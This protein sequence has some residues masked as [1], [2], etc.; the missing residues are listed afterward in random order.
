MNIFNTKIL[1]NRQ[2]WQR[3]LLFSALGTVLCILL[4][5]FLQRMFR[6][7]SS[8]FYL[9]S[10]LFMG[11]LIQESGHGV[12]KKFSILAVVCMILIIFFSD[13]FYFFGTNAL[14]NL[15]TAMFY[16]VQSYLH[17]DFSSLLSLLIKAAF[18]GIAY[19]RARVL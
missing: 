19:E 1:N 12:Q 6:I 16:T 14:Y 10:S 11:W 13:M 3:A 4:C 7:H 9:I 5:S 2:R 18:I 17:I 15:P 8:L